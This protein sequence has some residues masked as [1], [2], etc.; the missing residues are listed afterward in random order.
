MA[1]ETPTNPVLSP[2]EV[3]V[4][5]LD[6]GIL[7]SSGTGSICCPVCGPYVLASVETFLKYAEATGISNSCCTNVRASVETYLKY[8]EATGGSGACSNGFSAEST[9]LLDNL[10]G[11]DRNIILDKGIVESGALNPDLSSSISDLTAMVLA[12]VDSTYNEEQLVEILAV[13]L[14]KGIVV[15]CFP[16]EIIIASVETYLK[17][18]EAVG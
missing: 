8:S 3:L 5:A 15:S 13:L 14:D 2:L 10:S 17:W 11:E 9:A 12:F 16:G 7:T 1:E 6:D 18:A 4:N